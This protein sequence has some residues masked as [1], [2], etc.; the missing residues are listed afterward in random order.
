MDFLHLHNVKTLKTPILCVNNDCEI[1]TGYIIW[2]T[3]RVDGLCY[4]Y[5]PS[6]FSPEQF[7]EAYNP[8]PRSC[9]YAEKYQYLLAIGMK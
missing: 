3:A 4:L 2:T 7:S 9:M 1:K 5:M 8:L 6:L